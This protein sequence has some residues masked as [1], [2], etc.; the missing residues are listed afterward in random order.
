MLSSRDSWDRPPISDN[1]AILTGNGAGQL[2]A[3]TTHSTDPFPLATDFSDLD[4]DGDLDWV[5]AS[6]SGDWFIFEN[7]GAGV[8]SFHQEI[9]A[10]I[11][12]SCSLALDFDNDGDLDLALIDELAD[13]VILMR[14]G[15]V[16]PCIS[17]GDFD[18]SG[19]CD[20]LDLSPFVAA[21][22]QGANWKPAQLCSGDFDGNGAIGTEDIDP[23]V[24]CLLN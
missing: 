7:N 6:F 3:P 18:V 11:A 13:E 24:A 17:L 12:A 14:N 15:G 2:A 21:I 23:F 1:G 16:G 8:F 19:T 20:G 9:D 4:G 5:T 10:P 22:M